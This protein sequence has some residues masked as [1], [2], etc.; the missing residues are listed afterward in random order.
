MS[1]AFS[2][3]RFSL[4][5]E[6]R[7]RPFETEVCEVQID[8]CKM[9][10]AFSTR[11][12]S[13]GT[14]LRKWPRVDARHVN[15]H[16]PPVRQA[17]DDRLLHLLKFVLEALQVF[18]HLGAQFPA[19]PGKDAP[20][21]GQRHAV[22]EVVIV[23]VDLV[24]QLRASHEP[25]RGLRWRGN[26]WHV[27][28]CLDDGLGEHG[29]DLGLNAT[30]SHANIVGFVIQDVPDGTGDCK[31]GTEFGLV[32]LQ[33]SLQLLILVVEFLLRWGYGDNN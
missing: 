29:T 24:A 30:Y 33:S 10:A 15:S 13:F 25:Q 26:T 27:G 5:T 1:A 7:K 8:A 22:D 32:R 17:F 20:D 2:P 11:R 31:V 28:Q 12:R 9:S 4:H 14:E 18:G 23:V 16:L 3:R 19:D 6:L 21:G